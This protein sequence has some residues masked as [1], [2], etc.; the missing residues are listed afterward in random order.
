MVSPLEFLLDSVEP[1]KEPQNNQSP[2]VCVGGGGQQVLT[3]LDLQTNRKFP[4]GHLQA[5]T[6]AVSSVLQQVFQKSVDVVTDT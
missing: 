4:G 3:Q 5:F 1:E 6:T 2:C